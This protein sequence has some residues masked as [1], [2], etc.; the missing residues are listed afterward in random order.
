MFLL[1]TINL[2]TGNTGLQ[3]NLKSGN[4]VVFT[5]RKKIDTNLYQIF[6]SGKLMS[7]S[8]SRVL[9]EGSRMRAQISWVGKRLQLKVHNKHEPFADLLLRSNIILTNETRMI[10]EGLIRSGMPLLPEYFDKI[11]QSLRK[12]RNID[13]RLI[14][15]LLLLID[16]G[17]PLS[18]KNITEILSFNGRHEQNQSRNW[19]KGGKAKKDKKTEEIKAEIKNQIKKT[20]SGNEL[21][22]YF[23]HRIAIHDNWL[24]IPLS[25]SFARKG[26]GILK[27][28]LDERFVV[29]NM[30]LTLN[31]GRDWEFNLVKNKNSR[32]MKV[33]GPKEISWEDTPSFRK[34]KEKLYN[35][36]I[37]FDDI[38]KESSVTD[39]FTEIISG[40]YDSID[41]M[42]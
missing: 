40:K 22:K 34:L 3:N 25:Y 39:G 5:V 31:D 35:I 13:D 17:I 33:R 26:T 15:I 32:E 10:A 12:H 28:R 30:V 6:L 27:L 9:V 8:S 37:Q 18:E 11:Q 36:G 2:K 29:T 21:L 41:F 16:K 14:K 1:E 38:N 4:I 24:F 20:D 42:I 7:V 19:K 23:N